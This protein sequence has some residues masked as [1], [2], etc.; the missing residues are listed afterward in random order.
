MRKVNSLRKIVV[1]TFLFF[2]SLNIFSKPVFADLWN[3]GYDVVKCNINEF[4]IK[5]LS[6]TMYTERINGCAKYE[7]NSNYRHL[8]DSWKGQSKYC[9]K[10]KLNT[11]TLLTLIK[12]ILPILSI[13]LILELPI[14][15]IFLHKERKLFL[16]A[17]Y[18]NLIS[19]PIFTLSHTLIFKIFQKNLTEEE[20]ISEPN[21]LVIKKI[22]TIMVLEFFVF[23]FEAWFIKRKSN[24]T[25][26]I[27]IFICSFIAN[28]ISATIGSF[29]FLIFNARVYLID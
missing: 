18:A 24:E 14:F 19:I 23:L 16:T 4:E 11:T 7:N 17:I 1:T 22:V 25:K 13:T 29:I 15:W 27:K 2:I 28:L 8:T 20:L 6:S 3:P 9:L 12:K 26:P 10:A 21:N 5:C